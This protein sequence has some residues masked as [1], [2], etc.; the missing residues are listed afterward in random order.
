[1]FKV[2]DY[3]VQSQR[4]GSSARLEP[5]DTRGS[6][7][8]ASSLFVLLAAMGRLLGARLGGRVAGVHINMAE[9]LSLFRKSALL[10]FA[11][12]IGIPVV[13]HLHAAQ[14]HHFYRS[15]PAPVRALVRWTFARASRVVVL[16]QAARG[17][18]VNELKLPADRVEVVTNGVPP[19]VQQRA[20]LSATEPRARMLFLGNL[21]ERKGVTDLLVAL[22]LSD[23]A[24][25]GRI[26]AV[27]A[28]G[29]DVEGYT[30]KARELGVDGFTRFIGWADQAQA[31]QWVASADVLVLPSYDEGLP[32]VILEALA[33][34]VAVICTPVGEI[35]HTLHDGEDVLMVPPGDHAALA[36]ALDRVVG[37]EGLRHALEQRG[38]ALY[39][40]QFSL[41]HFAD[42]VADVHQRVFGVRAR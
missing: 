27:F 10:L 32:L 20:P 28:G 15:L 34:G 25:A 41:E 36:R 21:S 31:A 5:L 4:S 16:G 11:R 12:A 42:A 26:D 9:R 1:M 38:Q 39:R 2:A 40:Q 29:G 30:R 23:Q 18:V 24:R 22:S 35:P 8:P 13:L 33:N 14:L 19:P 7:R 6:G 37:D 3:L 17:F